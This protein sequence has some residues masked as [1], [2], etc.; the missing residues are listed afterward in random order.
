MANVDQAALQL[1]EGITMETTFQ[2]NSIQLLDEALETDCKKIRYGSEFC[3]YAIP[4]QN[5]LEKA[6]NKVFDAGKEFVYV[7]PRLADWALDTV[8]DQISF[9]DKQGGGTVV[10]NDLG[11]LNVLNEYENIKSHLGRQ[12][13][14]T[15]SRCPWKEITENPVSIFTKRKVEKIFYQTAF[16]YET[17]IDF[18]K[19]RNVIGADVDWIPRIFPTLK[20]ITKK[21]IDVSVHLYSI[22]I[23]I[24]RKCHMAR[25]LGEKD[26]N[27]CS[28]PCNREAYYME[29]EALG[30]EFYLHGNAVFRR[31][32]PEKG[33]L[34]KLKKAGVNELIFSLS[35]MNR[36]YSVIKE[37]V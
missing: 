20:N 15:P 11:T 27:T 34:S 13:I 9:L 24:T 36:D 3:I 7:T 35:P 1:G 26:L 2:V 4:S 18:Y 22:P 23:A 14:Y 10:L 25:F 31:E 37:L 8:K 12:L 6:Y 5:E 29:N 33:S 28:R 19:E 16:N 30:N 17:T 32:A 21:G